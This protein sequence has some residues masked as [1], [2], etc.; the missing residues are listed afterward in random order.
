MGRIQSNIGLSTGT[1]IQHTLSA[2]S[3]KDAQAVQKVAMEH[4]ARIGDTA[5]VVGAVPGEEQ[6]QILEEPIDSLFRHI[7]RERSYAF[8]QRQ[9]VLLGGSTY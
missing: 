5:Q 6:V 1:D 8:L 7:E 3:R 9:A 4:L 2:D